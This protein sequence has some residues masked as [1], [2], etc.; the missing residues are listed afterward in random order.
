MGGIECLGRAV[1][2]LEFDGDGTTRRQTAETGDGNP[3]VDQDVVVVCGVGKD[4][5]EDA[6][7]FEIG[8]VNP[9]EGA[10]EDGDTAQMAR[11]HRGVF[12][13]GALAVVLVSDGDPVQASL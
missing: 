5:W 11:F 8:L 12:A 7:L 3:V 10:N 4:Q 1:V 13:G 6:L 2:V 9:G